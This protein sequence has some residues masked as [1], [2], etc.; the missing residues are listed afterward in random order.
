MITKF[1][2]LM[3]HLQLEQTPIGKLLLG[4]DTVGITLSIGFYGLDL[5]DWISLY[6][7]P[8]ILVLTVVSLVTSIVYKTGFEIRQYKKRKAEKKD[9]IK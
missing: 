3:Q 9:S 5:G 6:L 4:F 1:N 2:E 8:V 7:P